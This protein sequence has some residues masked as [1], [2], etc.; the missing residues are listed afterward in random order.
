M[1]LC[2]LCLNKICS[3]LSFI[4]GTFTDGL[5]LCLLAVP[6]LSTLMILASTD[7]CQMCGYNGIQGPSVAFCSS[8]SLKVDLQPFYARLNLLTC[9]TQYLLPTCM[10]SKSNLTRKNWRFF[11]ELFQGANYFSLPRLVTLLVPC[12]ERQKWINTSTLQRLSLPWQA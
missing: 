2:I 9:A 1:V 12:V 8:S 6:W 7:F 10:R 5:Y 11:S 3:V 4:I